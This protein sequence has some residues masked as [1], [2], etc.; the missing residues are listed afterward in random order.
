MLPQARIKSLFRLFVD[1]VEDI[2]SFGSN[3]SL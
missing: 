1:L 2:E 3:T